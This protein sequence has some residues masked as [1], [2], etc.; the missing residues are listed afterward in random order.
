MRRSTSPPL[1]LALLP[2]LLLLGCEPPG[3]DDD[4][5]GPTPGPDELCDIDPAY[6]SP[7]IES[8]D[9]CECP[10]T[11]DRCEELGQAEGSFQTRWAITVSDVDGD[12]INPRYLLG[13][14]T[15]PPYLSGRLEGSLGE[16]GTLNV[17]IQGC[18]LLTRNSNVPWSARMTDQAGCESDALEGVW[19][20]PEFEGDD[21]C[22]TACGPL[23]R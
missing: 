9:G 12:L 13:V 17:E 18:Y 15:F 3:D 4:S 22:A 8:V 16:G 21:D 1:A 2:A 6:N 5:G 11:V 19:F 10:G 14:D 23:G 7:V 20:V